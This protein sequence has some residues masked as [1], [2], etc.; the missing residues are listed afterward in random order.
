MFGIFINRNDWSGVFMFKKLSSKK[1]VIN[2]GS[3]VVLFELIFE[4]VFERLE[5]IVGEFEFGWLGLIEVLGKYENG[6]CL[7]KLCY[8][9]L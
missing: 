7:F 9:L 6:V 5:S 1:K 4:E 8:E 2:F 3:D